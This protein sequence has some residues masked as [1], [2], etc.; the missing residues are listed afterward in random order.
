VP[1][2]PET[3]GHER[4]SAVVSARGRG[5]PSAV[6][7]RG[8]YPDAMGSGSIVRVA[9]VNDYE[10]VVAGTAA[11][12]NEHDD[13]IEV[14]ELDSRLPVVSDVD[15]VLYDSFGQVQGAAI[16]FDSLVASGTAKVVVFSWNDS[17]ELVEQSLAAGAHGYVSKGV[18]GA[19]LV[20]AL[21][22]VHA[23]ERVTPALLGQP[24]GDEFGVWPGS[25]LGLSPRSPRCWP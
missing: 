12:L 9:I 24:T 13:R 18:S 15:V 19:G 22:R 21:V 10:I 11:V 1:A 23:G 20:D 5:P 2:G 14:V 16:D 6:A 7:A 4:F 3:R 17:A 25:E 8:P